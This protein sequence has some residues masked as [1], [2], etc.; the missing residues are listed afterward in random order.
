MWPN[1][2]REEERQ[3]G[4][5]AEFTII[6]QRHAWQFIKMRHSSAFYPAL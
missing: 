1:R 3:F 2:D 4:K 6:E 5:V